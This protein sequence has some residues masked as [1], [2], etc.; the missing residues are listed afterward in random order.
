MDGES[1][2]AVV[3]RVAVAATRRSVLRASVGALAGV[4][5]AGVGLVR[6][7]ADAGASGKRCCRK[8]RR[9]FSR[10]QRECEETGG[11]LITPFSC[12]RATCDPDVTP[13]WLCEVRIPR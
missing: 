4:A 9:K 10:A 3:Q 12:D 6:L 5:L 11:V 1:F 2:D 7:P 13:E 8:Q